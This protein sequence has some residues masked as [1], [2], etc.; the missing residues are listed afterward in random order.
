[1]YCKNC[2]TELREGA[3]V[4]IVCGKIVESALFKEKEKDPVLFVVLGFIFAAIS[5]FL[6]PPVFGG[7]G[8]YFGYKTKKMGK[9]TLGV[10][11]M[12]V[13]AICMIIGMYLGYV[14]AQDALK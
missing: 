12:V 14:T 13:C 2:G 3:E 8:I 9:D 4:C 11:L 1:M 7:L 6:F 10:V 5:V